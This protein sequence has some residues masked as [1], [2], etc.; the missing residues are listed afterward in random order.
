MTLSP[1]IE[2]LL[3][4]VSSKPRQRGNLIFALDATASRERTW[5]TASQLQASMFLE[6]VGIGELDLQLVYF[7]GMRGVNAE[8]KASPWISDPVA[9]A[10]LMAK[11]KC[12][13]GYTQIERVLSHASR[14]TSQRKIGAVV[15][16]G[17]ACEEHP[18][19][20]LKPAC[21]LGGLGVPVFMF[22]EGR[23]SITRDRFQKI[24][25]ATHGAYHSFDQGSAKLLGELLKAVA[26]FAVGGVLALERQ[27]SDAAKRLLGQIR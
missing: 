17:D 23:D 9:L 25:E 11:I 15:Y 6:V 1:H 20:L 2:K 26:A 8:C 18:E 3:A 7:R 12:E 21:E 22:Q 16:V 24:A 10:R 5:D 4:E 13:T 19:T 27:G 14:E